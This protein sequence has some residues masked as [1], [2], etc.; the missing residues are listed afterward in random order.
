MPKILSL[1]EQIDRNVTAYGKQLKRDMRAKINE[2]TDAA[3]GEGDKQT[4]KTIKTVGRELLSV[5]A[6]GDAAE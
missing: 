1:E 3:V 4:A 2:L 6:G 5:L